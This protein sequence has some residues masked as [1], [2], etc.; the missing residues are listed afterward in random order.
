MSIPFHNN[1][2]QTLQQAIKNIETYN[3]EVNG[4]FAVASMLTDSALVGIE[5]PDIVQA[6]QNAT[7][8]KFR[9]VNTYLQHLSDVL[10]REPDTHE[11]VE[12]PETDLLLPETRERIVLYSPSIRLLEQVRSILA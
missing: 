12:H 3:K 7:A 9:V 11:V 8:S 2:W 1:S 5:I 6:V 4:A 10:D